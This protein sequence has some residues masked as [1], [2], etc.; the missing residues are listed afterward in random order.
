MTTNIDRAAEVLEPWRIGNSHHDMAQA[1]AAAGLLASD[2]VEPEGTVEGIS[3]DGHIGPLHYWP[4]ADVECMTNP[5]TRK[6]VVTVFGHQVPDPDRLARQILSA[7]A[8]AEKY[9]EK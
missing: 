3:Q 9:E 4:R 8:Y 5:H 6:N 1:L 7:A 2:P